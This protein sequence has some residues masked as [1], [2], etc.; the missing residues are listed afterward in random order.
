M[1]DKIVSLALIFAHQF[2]RVY[3]EKFDV[4]YSLL[5]RETNLHVQPHNQD[6]TL[7]QNLQR[8]VLAYACLLASKTNSLYPL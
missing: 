6:H 5:G 4:T 8:L 1:L 7:Y 3:Q 2:H